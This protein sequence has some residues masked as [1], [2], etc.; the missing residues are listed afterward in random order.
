MSAYHASLLS[1]AACFVCVLLIEVICIMA[2]NRE[3]EDAQ[4]AESEADD[5][6]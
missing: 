5:G 4:A 6:D 2:E 3:D 1:I